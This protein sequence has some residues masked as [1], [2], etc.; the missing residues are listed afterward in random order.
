M[1]QDQDDPRT[2]IIRDK[3]GR[4]RTR[5]ELVRDSASKETRPVIGIIKGILDLLGDE[6]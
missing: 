1:P 6:L 2:Q 3:I 4:L 5:L